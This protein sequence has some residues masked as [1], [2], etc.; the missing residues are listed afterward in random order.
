[1]GDFLMH[2]F[3]PNSHLNVIENAGHWVH[4]ERPYE[5][6]QIVSTFLDCPR[7]CIFSL[8]HVVLCSILFIDIIAMNFLT[9][10]IRFFSL[11]HRFSRRMPHSPQNYAEKL[12]LSH[13]HLKNKNDTQNNIPI[14]I[15]HGLLGSKSNWRSIARSLH[16]SGREV[17]TLDMRNHGHS[18]ASP[19]MDYDIMAEDV[20]HTVKKQ[21]GDTQFDLVGH[22]MGGKVAMMVALKQPNMVRK[23]VIVDILPIGTHP[24]DVSETKNIVLA[25]RDIQ[26]D[27][28][29][30]LPEVRKSV[31][32]QL[33]NKISDDMVA[34]WLATN[35]D[36]NP[37]KGVF[38]KC[39]VEN[40]HSAIE[41]IFDFPKVSFPP[42]EGPVLFIQG[43]KSRH[44]A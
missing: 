37:E 1:M 13:E 38:W 21:V 28:T 40:L 42:F 15:K 4:A 35:L 32:A 16:R 6:I 36:W 30:P 41:N 44:M 34:N 24:L 3:F 29:K 26:I 19:F 8:F 39:H 14:V 9:E 10:K 20:L 11:S 23:A 5:F 22:S 18:L 17:L 7:V 31:V 27:S 12:L 25:L 2:K 33:K 43:E